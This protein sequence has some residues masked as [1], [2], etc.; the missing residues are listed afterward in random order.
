M[1]VWFDEIRVSASFLCW[2]TAVLLDLSSRKVFR[3]VQIPGNVAQGDAFAMQPC[4]TVLVAS[5]VDAD[6]FGR[7]RA[8]AIS[9]GG[10]TASCGCP[11][12]LKGVRP[13]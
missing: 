5:K 11:V 3:I 12:V 7:V 9:S 2:D 10:R 1:V 8:H 4:Q 6:I 13:C